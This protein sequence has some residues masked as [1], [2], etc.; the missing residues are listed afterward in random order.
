MFV[1]LSILDLHTEHWGLFCLLKKMLIQCQTL[2]IILS[3]RFGRCIWGII[4]SFTTPLTQPNGS[5]LLVI[6][7]F[8]IL[9]DEIFSCIFYI[10][11][12]YWSKEIS[13]GWITHSWDTGH[14]VWGVY[15]VIS[16]WLSLL[17]VEDP[18]EFRPK[19]N[20]INTDEPEDVVMENV[21]RFLD[22]KY[23]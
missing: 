13:I 14:T 2:V 12:L 8:I 18:Y 3:P 10:N 17:W 5:E 1:G 9:C 19:I 23:K 22:E 20:M 6:S 21:K 15:C 7:Q 16:G 11:F 4:S